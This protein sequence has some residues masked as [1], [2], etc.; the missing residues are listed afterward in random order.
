MGWFGSMK[1][2]S[3]LVLLALVALLP[4]AILA[5]I[6]GAFLIEQQ[7]ETFRQGS[8]ARVHAL[9]TAVDSELHGSID[10]LRAL[11]N[12]RSLDEED[13]KF[14]RESAAQILRTQDNWTT[15]NLARPDG[16]QIVNLLAPEG[17]PLPKLPS[18]EDSFARLL[19]TMKPAVGDLVVGPVTKQ[20]DFAVRVPV[21]RDGKLQYVLSA[22]VKPA[23]IGRLVTSQGLPA[24]W[25]GM[26]LDRNGRIVARTAQPE[27]IGELAVEG[28][29]NAMNESASGWYRATDVEGAPRYRVYR[30]SEATGWTF[31]MAIPAQAVDATAIRAVWFF[32]LALVGAIVL[33]FALAR[34]VGR[35]IAGPITALAA[36]TDRLAQ[37]ADVEIKESSSL[38]EIRTLETALRNAAE[39]QKALRRERERLDLALAAGRM[40]AFEWNPIERTTWW[41]PE[42]YSMHGVSPDSFAPQTHAIKLVHPEDVDKLK[43]IPRAIEQHR[44]WIQEYRIIRPDGEV[45]WLAGRGE[46]E[47]DKEGR[48]HRFYGV[49]TDIT[50]RKLMEHA[51]RAAD[52]H[53]DEFL[54]MLSHELRNPLAALTTA[55][56]VLRAAA[57]HD[58]TTAKAQGVI[59]RQTQHMVRLIDDLLDITRVRLGKL[60]L[61]PEPLNLGEL[62]SEVTQAKRAAGAFSARASVSVDATTV[63]IRG[64]RARLEQVYSNLLDNALKFTP[65]SGSIR[66]SVRQE[67][68]QA[69]LCIADNGRGIP[70]EL[71]PSIFELFVQGEQHL[72]RAQGGLG[73]G[74]ALVRRLVELH[75]GHVAAASDGN[76]QGAT[77]T[78]S[79]PAIQAPAELPRSGAT[80]PATERKPR[81]I[82]I[83]EDNQDAR[84]M[85]R[86]VFA[87]QGHDVREAA[88]GAAGLDQAGKFHP[89][90]ALLDIGL[91]DMD[92]YEVARCLRAGPAG[93]S[94]VLVA[95]SG[96]GRDDDRGRAQAAGFDAH[97]VK[98]ASA[99][100]IG[101]L[102]AELIARKRI[103][104]A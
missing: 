36:A 54:A 64:D 45:R 61:K 29:R 39:A 70:A 12:V 8:H 3:Q 41:S 56:H 32:G 98:P 10:V 92:G 22:V 75:G 91:P 97:V 4:V 21:V 93:S 84:Q 46:T 79:L 6:L 89:E 31:A 94:M 26:V 78:V 23:S 13:L 104:A 18:S 63:W 58:A 53:K 76:G 55:A 96:Y 99:D 71:L 42:V 30:R 35:T 83:V 101:D 34:F 44:P 38:G 43:D 47:Y 80:K 52:R 17:A 25:V 24:D 72:H 68:T 2:R 103:T 65:A 57:P 59:D 67:A 48:G 28:L 9:I 37:G 51:L 87:L 7:R 77:F 90:V 81:R 27:N 73:L 69:V 19:R 86:A 5:A 60:S 16:Q 33:A 88:S 11:G 14:F 66:V 1:V 74:L 95:L 15:I 62:V 102:V 82:L 49:V 85:L 40:G 50:E 20:W 100:E